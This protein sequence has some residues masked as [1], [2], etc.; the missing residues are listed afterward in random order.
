M[1]TLDEIHSNRIF[2]CVRCGE[3]ITPENYSGW[4][5]FMPDGKT[6]QPICKFCDEEDR[7]NC[8]KM[9][10]AEDDFGGIHHWLAEEDITDTGLIWSK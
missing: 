10:I 3:R 1:I 6:T 9:K 7:L 4:E 5:A 8:G 2:W